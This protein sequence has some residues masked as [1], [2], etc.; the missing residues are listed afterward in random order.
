MAKKLSF[1]KSG[2]L[3]AAGRRC[4]AG[5]LAAVTAAGAKLPADYI[6]RFFNAANYAASNQG[7]R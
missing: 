2:R 3:D 4:V 5:W 7:G 6:E 1:L